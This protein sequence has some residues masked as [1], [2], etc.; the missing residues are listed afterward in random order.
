MATR[1]EKIRMVRHFA[2]NKIGDIIEN[3]YD[4]SG[5][6]MSHVN[7]LQELLTVFSAAEIAL[8]EKVP[9]INEL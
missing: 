6:I 9:S 8:E 3:D 7:E 1:E 5:D 4:S 2:I